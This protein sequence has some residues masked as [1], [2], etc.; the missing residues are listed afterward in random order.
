MVYVNITST[1]SG[2]IVVYNLLG[3]EVARAAIAENSLNKLSLNVPQG[4]YFVK[5]NGNTVNGAGKVFIR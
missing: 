4:Y 3:C 2:N 5:V 1:M